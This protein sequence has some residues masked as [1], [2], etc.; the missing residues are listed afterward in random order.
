MSAN[1]SDCRYAF[2]GDQVSVNAIKLRLFF[3]EWHVPGADGGVIT[4]CLPAAQ[5]R[6]AGCLD[7]SRRLTR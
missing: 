3:W 7:R 1:H 4:G 2:R 5:I 6:V